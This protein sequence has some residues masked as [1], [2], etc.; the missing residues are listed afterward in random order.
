MEE[1]VTLGDALF[2]PMTSDRKLIWRVCRDGRN[3]M[4]KLFCAVRGYV[5]LLEIL[6]WDILYFQL[7]FKGLVYRL[8]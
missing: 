1:L 6:H 3:C 2:L 5:H 8:M 7:N 4:W